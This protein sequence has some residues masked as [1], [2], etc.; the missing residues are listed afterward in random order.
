M[1][2][3]LECPQDNRVEQAPCP[4]QWPPLDCCLEIN[5]GLEATCKVDVIKN[6]APS[7]GE[8]NFRRLL[9]KCE[10]MVSEAQN[11]S[12]AFEWRIE[13]VN[14][15]KAIIEFVFSGL[16]PRSKIIIG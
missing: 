7:Q 5:S 15:F 10:K 16:E 1:K 9:G 12:G 14:Y 4:H 13:K 8:V 6:M 2:G 11:D 3:N